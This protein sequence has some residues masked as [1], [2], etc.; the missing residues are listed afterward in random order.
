M[1]DQPAGAPGVIEKSWERAWTLGELRED[2]R[3]WNLGND[4]G[5]L[6]YLQDFSNSLIA[7]TKEVESQVDSLVL[8]TKSA[9]VRVHNT[10]NEF[11]MLSNFQF[12]ENRVYDDDTSLQATTEQA[13]ESEKIEE[14]TEQILVPKYT[15]AIGF[16]MQALQAQ[17]EQ[18]E[19]DEEDDELDDQE[20]PKKEK[21]LDRFSRHPLPAVI[22]TKQFQDDDNC[23]LYY[24]DEEEYETSD[25]LS[26]SES[27]EEDASPKEEETKK[28]GSES[29]DELSKSGEEG[30]DSESSESESSESESSNDEGS[31]EESGEDGE[32]AQQK[33]KRKLDKQMARDARRKE[34]KEKKKA[35]EEKKKSRGRKEKSSQTTR[36]C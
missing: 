29:D 26:I 32:S 11:L 18:E 9:E 15:E 20:K 22:G 25:D 14:L 5:L 31:D 3:D 28:S 19:E 10:F 35:K 8:E 23:G 1:S 34:K 7:R 4:Y 33:I 30:S 21:Q 24:E 2:V 16:G 13:E 36:T 6:R 12:I 27:E 17:A